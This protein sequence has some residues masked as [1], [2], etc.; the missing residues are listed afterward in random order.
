MKISIIGAGNVGAQAA[1][2]IL[3]HDLA[4]IVL[5]DIQGD[6]ANAKALD[7]MDAGAISGYK[8]KIEGTSDYALT[9][10]SEVV[11]ITAGF[12]RKPG[13]SREEL[14]EKNVRVVSEVISQVKKYTPHSILIIVTNPLD[15]LTHL[16]L[17]LSGFPASRVMGMAGIL[18]AARFSVQIAK[19]LKVSSSEID[20]AILGSHSDKMLILSRLS[21]HNKQLLDKLLKPEELNLAEEK[22]RNRGAEIVELLKGGSA[23][24]AP[25]AGILRMVEAI[26]RD[27]HEIMPVSGYLDGH[28]G[29]KDITLGT[30]ARIGRKGIEEIIELDLTPGEKEFLHKTAEE[31]RSSLKKLNL[32]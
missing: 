19:S 22:T 21:R 15:I 11:V 3:E 17:K 1:M 24:F 32:F 29:L 7:L 2:R 26:V 20:S 23:F 18:D 8:S 30:L 31:M 16:A 25:S 9:E 12:T 28:Y 27:K 13:M 5:V 10:D 14:L 6:L 4:E